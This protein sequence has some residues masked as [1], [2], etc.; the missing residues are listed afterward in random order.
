[1]FDL[2]DVTSWRKCFGLYP[3]Q[4]RPTN[5]DQYALLND[6]RRDFCIDLNP[7]GDI[8]LYN[9]YAWS[10]NAKNYLT[11]SEEYVIIYNWLKSSP[12]KIKTKYVENNIATFYG[13][14]GT[15]AYI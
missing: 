10:A 3:I 12:E 1:M 6:G 8:D 14:L 4:I 15:Q 5:I 11:I 13:Y 7:Q 9:S 2:K